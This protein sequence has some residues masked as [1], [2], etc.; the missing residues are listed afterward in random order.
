MNRM[1]D[2]QLRAALSRR[3]PAA[4]RPADAASGNARALWEQIMTTPVDER[5]AT[6]VPARPR[7]RLIFALAAAA[8]AV[9]AGVGTAITLSSRTPDRYAP[10][11]SMQAVVMDLTMPATAAGA[12]CWPFDVATLRRAPVAFQGTALDVADTSVVLRVDR[13]FRGGPDGVTEVRVSRPGADESEGVAFT[14]G[15]TYLVSAQD[16]AVNVC[17]YTGEL[18]P[19]FLA[20]YHQAFGS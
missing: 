3:D 4:G 5:P 20:Y 2:D 19:E 11:Q 18:T 15:R 1:T 12:G 17:G 8:V 10:A 9:L 14:A 13:W 7:R 16:G 6:T